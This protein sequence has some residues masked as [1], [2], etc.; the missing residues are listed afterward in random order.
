MNYVSGLCVTLR[1]F[2]KEGILDD[3]ELIGQIES[4]L[5]SDL[6]FQV[7]DP[8]NQERINLINTVLDSVL[9]FLEPLVNS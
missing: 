9:N 6:T 1:A 3:A 2:I 4:F 7:N 8:K 5:E